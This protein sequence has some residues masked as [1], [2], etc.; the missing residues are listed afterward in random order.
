VAV[1]DITLSIHLQDALCFCE[2]D[3][4]G[5]FITKGLA[6]ILC[7]HLPT[8]LFPDRSA[9]VAFAKELLRQS[10]H[11]DVILSDAVLRSP[12]LG[13]VLD[14]II[15]KQTALTGRRISYSKLVEGRVD[16]WSRQNFRQFEEFHKAEL[17]GEQRRRPGGGRGDRS[18]L[19]TDP[20]LPSVVRALTDELSTAQGLAVARFPWTRR[21]LSKEEMLQ[22]FVEVATGGACP[23]LAAFIDKWSEFLICE[24]SRRYL[25]RLANGGRTDHPRHLRLIVLAYIAEYTGHSSSY[26]AQTLKGR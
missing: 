5:R 26:V 6:A 22:R 18:F 2:P 23:N 4:A 25:R 20:F 13:E 16:L 14:G 11:L 1:H 7:T 24:E 8:S 17:L 19:L 15:I 12:A 10:E 21:E 9:R 3:T